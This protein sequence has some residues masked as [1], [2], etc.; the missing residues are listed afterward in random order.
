MSRCACTQ[1]TSSHA[2]TRV[3]HAPHHTAPHRTR[4]PDALGP[5]TEQDV[6]APV[7][8]HEPC[9]TRDVRTGEL[10]MVSVNYPSVGEFSN[11]SVFNTSGICVCTPNC[12]KN[13]VGSRAACPC[14]NKG[15]H[16]FL[17][18]IRTATSATSS[19]SETMSPVLGNSD[20]N[21]ACWINKTGAVNCNGRGGGVQAFSLNWKNLSSWR[22]FDRCVQLNPVYDCLFLLTSCK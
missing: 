18:I 21:L 4:V 20:D 2:L 22:D 14:S 6:I 19:W 10:L 5:Y 7:F 1:R 17:H 13:A 12:T 3:S 15:H 16:P 9:V 8:A 11:T